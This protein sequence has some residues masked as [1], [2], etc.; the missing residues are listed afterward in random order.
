L[1]T[2]LERCWYGGSPV[3]SLLLP[4]SLL[5][6]GASRLR[7]WL[8]RRRLLN[9]TRMPVPVIVVGN[10]TVGG[11]GKTPIVIWLVDMLRAAGWCPGVVSRGYGGRGKGVLPV[12]PD[13][14]PMSVGDEPVLIARRCGCPVWVGRRRAAA[15]QSLLT[16]HPEVDVII[17]DDGLQHYALDRD[18][19]LVV[20]EGERGLGNGRLLPA[21]PLREPVNRLGKVDALVMNGEGRQAVPK[22]VPVFEM[23]LEGRTFWNLRDPGEERDADCF[24]AAPVQA[25]AGI[26]NPARFFSQLRH[27]GLQV[28]AI[29]FPDHHRFVPADIPEG[30]VI[31]TE[32]DA[33]KC[34]SWAS[35]DCWALRID[36]RLGEGLQSLIIERLKARHGQ[37]T[38]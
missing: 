10:I 18:L 32:K 3:F 4:L 2:L 11:S 38:A 31:M 36:A 13:S 14:N 35:E 23:C 33:V 1:S 9:V 34:M 16:Y 15:A 28:T 26:G 5:F 20:I 12:R 30:L 8:Y 29:S 24:A 17:S 7:R 19:E 37:Q 22:V 6:L 25:I 21:G 27:L